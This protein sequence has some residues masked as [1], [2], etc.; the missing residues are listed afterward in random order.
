M[1]KIRL[2]K[3]QLFFLLNLL[4]CAP[5]I[6]QNG[7]K[8][9]LAAGGSK[10]FIGYENSDFEPG[11]RSYT[12][13]AWQGSL[14][15]LYPL[16]KGF[17]VGVQ[18]DWINRNHWR[19]FPRNAKSDFSF[20]GDIVFQTGLALRKSYLT[21]NHRGFYWQTGISLIFP[22]APF[23]P[24]V[25]KDP[26]DGQQVGQVTSR[27]GLGI[28]GEIGYRIFNR[29]ENYFLVGLRYQQGLYRM[30]QLNIPIESAVGQP[31]V[32]QVYANGSFASLLM[33]YGINTGNW[34]KYNRKTPKRYFN[35]NKMIKHELSNQD[36]WFVTAY[37]GFRVKDPIT[38]Q[39]DFYF[40][41]SGQFSFVL[42]YK[43]RNYSLE[44]GY[45]QFSAGNNISIDHGLFMWTDWV[46]YGINTPHIPF[47][48]K[49]D[50]PISDLKTVRFG[51]IFGTSIFLRDNTN[52]GYFTQNGSGGAILPDGTKF[53]VAGSVKSVPI[54]KRQ[55]MLFNAG[56]HLEYQAFNSSFMS[57]NLSR[58]FNSP[59]ISRF[60]ADIK[61]DQT[62]YQFTQDATLDGFR[63]DFG[64]KLPL[65]V[66]DKQKKMLMK[67]R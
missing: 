48:F 4:I 3:I 65:N 14:R 43:W 11:F 62:R 1:E 27:L 46:V 45:G 19:T 50:I 12:K 60:E 35:E 67:H 54:E 38:P 37:G 24:T 16:K 47:T 41:S 55:Y 57:L 59:V 32:H 26:I 61:I 49:Y 28:N 40:N 56:I 25:G 20:L 39:Q 23:N 52:Q 2:G 22:P 17:E 36:G 9:E 21:P 53:E 34:N 30:E 15:G 31:A 58:N 18:A 7:I 8:L 29:R 13:L 6:A 5:T 64:W 33:A 10:S 42:G 63:F 51:P 44:S 66:L